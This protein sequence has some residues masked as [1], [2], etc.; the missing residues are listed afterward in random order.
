[1]R[2]NTSTFQSI[3][4]QGTLIKTYRATHADCLAAFIISV[5]IEVC[6]FVKICRFN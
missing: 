5:V 3:I 4:L 6:Y 1:M 2:E